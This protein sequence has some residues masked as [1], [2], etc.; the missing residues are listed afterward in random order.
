MDH[1]I[2]KGELPVDVI[3]MVMGVHGFVRS[4]TATAA[5]IDSR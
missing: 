5:G 3:S 2:D 1:E 4:Q